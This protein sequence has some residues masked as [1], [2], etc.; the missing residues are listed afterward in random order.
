MASLNGRPR[1]KLSPCRYALA[2]LARL[3]LMLALCLRLISRAKARRSKAK[4]HWP[5]I[6]GMYRAHNRGARARIEVQGYIIAQR[7]K[8]YQRP[9]IGD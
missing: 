4:A 1:P 5:P 2:A 9:F 8:A 6:M 3:C 7:A